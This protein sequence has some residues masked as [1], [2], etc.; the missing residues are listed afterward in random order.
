GK[1]LRPASKKENLP[2]DLLD[3]RNSLRSLVSRSAGILR[4]G[5]TMSSALQMLDFWQKYVYA[6][7]F[8]SVAGLELQNMLA[9]AQLI[10]RS[11]LRREE[12]RGAHF[13]SDF[14]DVDDVKF[15]KHLAISRKEF[16]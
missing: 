12:S 6:E 7:E 5:E 15:K 4:D 14:P 13:R 2:L 1:T 11:A 8:S 16:D 10:L 3:V 9:C